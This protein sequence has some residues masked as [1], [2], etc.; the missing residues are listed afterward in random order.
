MK[1]PKLLSEVNMAYKD[2]PQTSSKEAVIEITRVINSGESVY[3]TN[4]EA[5]RLMKPTSIRIKPNLKLKIEKMAR[6]EGRS[7]NNMVARLLE[8]ATL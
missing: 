4:E 3:L 7:F 6:K 2:C 1:Q 5:N 8:L